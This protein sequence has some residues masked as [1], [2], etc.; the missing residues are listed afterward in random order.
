MFVATGIAKYH[1]NLQREYLLCYLFSIQTSE[2]IFLIVK[3]RTYFISGLHIGQ[4]IAVSCLNCVPQSTNVQ[5]RLKAWTWDQAIYFWTIPA[6]LFK[7]RGF[8]AGDLC[9]AHT[10]G[11]TKCL[12]DIHAGARRGVGTDRC[13][14]V[15]DDFNGPASNGTVVG[16]NWMKSCL[17]VVEL[18]RRLSL[19]GV[20]KMVKCDRLSRGMCTA[21][22]YCCVST[23][24]Y[25]CCCC[26]SWCLILW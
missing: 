11:D 14:L 22:L 7:S 18:V 8:L 19:T 24:N 23:H 1:F 16:D 26:C 15:D 9:M 6:I 25:C 2:I 20:L 5:H 17:G 13:W 21:A 10:V 4:R 3:F 12:S